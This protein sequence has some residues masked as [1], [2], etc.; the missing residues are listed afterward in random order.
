[1]ST[2]QK[3]LKEN[4]KAQLNYVKEFLRKDA[5]SDH[6][7]YVNTM[8]NPITYVVAACLAIVLYID[9]LHFD[10]FEHLSGLIAQIPSKA[11]NI[12]S[13]AVPDICSWNLWE[14]A[15]HDWIS[16][17]NSCMRD[18]FTVSTVIILLL[19]FFKFYWSREI[20]VEEALKKNI[21]TAA[22]N[23][24]F[25]SANESKV[26]TN[27]GAIKV[28]RLNSE[29]E[30]KK[31][32]QHELAKLMS[33]NE[34]SKYAESKGLDAAEYKKK[35]WSLFQNESGRASG[36]SSPKSKSPRKQNLNQTVPL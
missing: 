6:V 3:N 21:D 29:K 25:N 9:Y 30:R 31:T 4:I 14:T 1:M 24:S 15:T 34:F 28:S 27:Q 33:S 8:I 10:H 32:T 11:C 5:Q 26:K 36:K 12:M 17:Q 16:L 22:L 19:T 2:A 18:T 35:H 7:R 23:F 13:I 20:T